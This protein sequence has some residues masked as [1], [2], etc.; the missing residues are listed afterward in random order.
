MKIKTLKSIEECH[1]IWI[2]IPQIHGKFSFS[3][4]SETRQ[5]DANDNILQ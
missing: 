1:L 4:H 5:E 2:W 3:T